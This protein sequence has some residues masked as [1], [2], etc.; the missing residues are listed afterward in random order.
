[1][2]WISFLFAGPLVR[3]LGVNGAGALNRVLGLFIMAIGVDLMVAGL[4]NSFFAN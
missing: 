2:T 3:L 1:M 4:K